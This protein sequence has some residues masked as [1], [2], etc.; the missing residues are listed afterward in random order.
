ME[1]RRGQD[2]PALAE[3]LLETDE[4]KERES[5]FLTGVMSGRLTRFQAMY[6][7]QDTFGKDKM[8]P[9]GLERGN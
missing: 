9:I 7:Y 1:G 5:V 2:A 3:H 4:F 8:P 6:L